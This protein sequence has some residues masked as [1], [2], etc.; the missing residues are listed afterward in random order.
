MKHRGRVA[1]ATHSSFHGASFVESG[2][3]SG[4]SRSAFFGS[5]SY[6]DTRR[7]IEEFPLAGTARVRS[8]TSI[9]PFVKA[10]KSHAL[11]VDSRYVSLRCARGS[12]E[13]FLRDCGNHGR[14]S[15][16]LILK[17]KVL[18]LANLRRNQSAR[19]ETSTPARRHVK[20]SAS[21]RSPWRLSTRPL[22]LPYHSECMPV[23]T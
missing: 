4:E 10:I 11:S 9:E 15:P 2:V 5:K 13:R 20:F 16:Y 22:A 1:S 6:S 3:V 7:G 17:G 21:N 8:T 14:L 12:P 19:A 18:W 23:K